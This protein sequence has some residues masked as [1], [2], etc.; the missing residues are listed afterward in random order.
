MF[1]SFSSGKHLD[2]SVNSSILA[3]LFINLAFWFWW[4]LE[5]KRGFQRWV[6]EIIFR[7][8]KKKSSNVFLKRMNQTYYIWCNTHIEELCTLV[9][10]CTFTSAGCP[11]RKEKKALRGGTR[12]PTARTTLRETRTTASRTWRLA[13]ACSPLSHPSGAS[14][15]WRS[16]GEH[17]LRWPRSKWNRNRIFNVGEGLDFR[18][19]AAGH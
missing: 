8:R 2:V 7:K 19:I 3:R 9:V 10:L 12:A 1:F 6:S 4:S 14:A 16:L 11:G 18:E 17:E 15:H 13:L 5:G